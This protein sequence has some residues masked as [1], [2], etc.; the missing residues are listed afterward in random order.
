MSFALTL[1]RSHAD[2]PTSP[3]ALQPG[4]R[5]GA[6]L[7][8]CPLGSLAPSLFLEKPNSFLALGLCAFRISA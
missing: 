3:G 7:S 2:P 4:L 6:I 8:P 5:L 1:R